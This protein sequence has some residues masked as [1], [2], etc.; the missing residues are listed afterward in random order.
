MRLT[1]ITSAATTA[2]SRALKIGSA[3]RPAEEVLIIGATV[4]TA[5]ELTR[6]LA[7]EKR[8]SFGYHQVT[9]RQLASAHSKMR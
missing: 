8:A 4:S 5:N 3:R 9:L 1:A 6:G 7:Q 2:A